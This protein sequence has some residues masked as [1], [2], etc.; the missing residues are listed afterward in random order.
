[1]T[2]AQQRD[3]GFDLLTYANVDPDASVGAHVAQQLL[4]QKLARR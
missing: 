3:D 1:M 4:E 2:C